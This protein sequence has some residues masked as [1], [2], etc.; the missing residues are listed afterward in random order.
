MIRQSLP[1]LAL[2]GLLLA[3]GVQAETPA[4]PSI[5][6][7]PEKVAATVLSAETQGVVRFDSRTPFDM[8]VLLKHYDQAA[9]YSG[10]GHLFL[11]RGAS[12]QHKV[13]AMVILPG[14]GG[15]KDGREMAYGKLLSE[16]G[17]AAIIIDYYGPR[18]I[19]D[20]APYALK[21]SS[22]SEFDVVADAYAALR[23]LN[24]HPA[25][26][27]RRIGVMGFSRGGIATRLTMDERI[28]SA[29]AADLPAF[30]LH[31][32]YY[33]PC[34]QEFGTRKTT[35][36]PLLSLRGAADV[37]NDLEQCARREHQLRLGGSKVGSQIYADA[38]H[39]WENL[40]PR[41]TNDLTYV[42]GCDV[43]YDE[44]GMPTIAGRTMIPAS[45]PLDRASRFQLRITSGQYYV[46]CLHKGYIVGRDEPV[47][48]ESDR[49]LIG[50]LD[51]VF[52]GAK[53]Y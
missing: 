33:G 2:A 5:T 4:M 3:A 51:Q 18:G 30:A 13:P 28:K 42:N 40:E 46:G 1:A 8:D 7:L 49:Q 38:G 11:P 47:K 22:V 14:S 37:T 21:A 15:I 23:M 17:Y 27:A 12:A 10:L 9:P 24:Q 45:T 26:D 31:V 32:D 50:F 44:G 39:S 35:G 25:V 34:F 36:A 48:Q 19:T 41:H 6:P 16:R 29:L 43:V 53:H 52:N 20:D